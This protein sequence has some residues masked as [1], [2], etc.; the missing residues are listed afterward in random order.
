MHHMLQENIGL[1]T[2]RQQNTTGFYHAFVTNTIV[3]S[4]IVSNQTREISYLFPL[5]L[6]Q[7]KEKPKKRSAGSIMMLF[8]PQE[9]YQARKPNLP[10]ALIEALTK[11]FKKSLS[12]EQ[13]FYYIYAVLYSNT[14]RTKYAEFLK[15]DFPRIPFTKDYKL[16]NRISEYGKRLVELHL[17]K[18]PDLDPAI[19][20][21]QG[22]G[23][24]KVEKLKYDRKEKRLY[25]NQ[26]QYFEGITE[27]VW[28]YQ[29][30]G[31]QVCD[32]WLKDRKGK[33][34]SLEDV[35]HYSRIVISLLKTIKIQKSI[36]DVYAGVE[37]DI[38]EI[39]LQK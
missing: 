39:E 23:D 35:R 38:I 4:C 7:E 16:F 37:K 1:L 32:K 12:P 13:I 19:L 28:Q 15:I 31:Y 3:E 30:G 29:I 22:K 20:R 34:L 5:Y 8:E 2:C 14:Y 9:G 17:L 24:N 11:A 18:S 27:D 6:Y 33:R 36:D 10:P 25:L 26:N 21:L